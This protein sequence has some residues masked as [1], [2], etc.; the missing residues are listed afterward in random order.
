M[1]S[2]LGLGFPPLSS[3][4]LTSIYRLSREQRE[5]MYKIARERIF[6]S[7]EDTP[8]PGMNKLQGKPSLVK[9]YIHIYVYMYVLC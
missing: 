4:D 5:E 6:G 1:P 3:V 7:A 8:A 9:I 2:K